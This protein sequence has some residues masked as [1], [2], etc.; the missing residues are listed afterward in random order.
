MS[1]VKS[2]WQN[3][4]HLIQV[5]LS[6]E[7][8]RN[9]DRKAFF[10]RPW[11]ARRSQRSG[12]GSL[13]LV[14]GTLRHSIL[15]EDDPSTGT[16]TWTSSEPYADIQNNGGTIT[17]TKAMKAHAWKEYYKLAPHVQ[18]TKRG[19]LSHRKKNL[20][21][22]AECEMWKAIA[23]MKPSSKIEIPQRQFIGNHPQVRVAIERVCTANVGD[24][25]DLISEILKVHNQ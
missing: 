2:L 20:E 11:R 24:L 6:D 22:A 19:E 25:A 14:K 1:S 4:V 10:D 23:L 16:I 9:F 8:D 15:P 5:E 18:Y 17:V 3:L 12:R 21:L 7:F 13:L